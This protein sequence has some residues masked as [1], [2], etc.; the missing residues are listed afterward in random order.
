MSNIN[1]ILPKT[2]IRELKI[3]SQ[4]I[5]LSF[6]AYSKTGNYIGSFNFKTEISPDNS[7]EFFSDDLIDMID[8]VMEKISE[9]IMKKGA[10]DFTKMN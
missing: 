1:I 3:E 2:K 7:D 8:D 4:K 9:E 10:I 5:D 6:E